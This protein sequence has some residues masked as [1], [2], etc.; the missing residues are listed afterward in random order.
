MKRF[1]PALNAQNSGVTRLASNHPF[2]ETFERL[3][4]QV[5]A[6]GLAVFTRIDF[7]GDAAKAGLTLRPMRALVFGNPASGTPL[8]IAAPTAAIDLPLKVVVYEDD[9]G[10]VWISYNSP[11]YIMTRHNIP[12]QL[13]KNIGGITG[14]VESV[15]T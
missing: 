5:A 15:A 14:I 1:R 10:K 2:S 8:M 9:D 13:L 7:S 3:E 6:R 11:Q 12:E 4:S